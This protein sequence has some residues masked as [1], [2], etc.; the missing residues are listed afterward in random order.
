[1]NVLEIIILGEDP[2]ELS[3][4]DGSTL[5]LKV[6]AYLSYQVRIQRGGQRVRTPPGK[7]QVIWVFYWE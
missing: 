3:S 7:L 6:S 2:S 4:G 5:Q 1:M